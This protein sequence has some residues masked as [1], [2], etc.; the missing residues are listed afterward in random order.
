MPT[1]TDAA[2]FE[3]YVEGWVTDNPQ[4]LDRLL[5][6]A[7]RDVDR[8]LGAWWPD[9]T[10]GLKITV[11]DLQTWQAAALS[12][13]VCAQAE[14][15]F[16]MGEDYFVRGQHQ[17]VIGPDFQAKGKLPRFSP[18]AMEELQGAGLVRLQ[19]RATPGRRTGAG[20]WR[21]DPETML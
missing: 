8:M 16:K 3:A 7:E 2:A 19:G 9:E 20:W 17:E 1:Y 13:A 4:A 11:A 18:K 12:R 21:R 10:T 6:R 14:Y 15:R 5:E